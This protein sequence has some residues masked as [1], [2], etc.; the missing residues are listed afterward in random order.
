MEFDVVALTAAI[1]AGGISFGKL[2]RGP[3]SGVGV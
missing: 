1:A 3:E 2:A